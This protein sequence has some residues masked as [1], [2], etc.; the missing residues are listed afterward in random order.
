[1]FDLLIYNIASSIKEDDDKWCKRLINY[2][3]KKTSVL[4]SFK[5]LAY[6]L[7]G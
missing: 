7:F 2:E 3:M 4:I 5:M 1:M 6:H